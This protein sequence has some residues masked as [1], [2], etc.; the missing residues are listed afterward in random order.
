VEQQFLNA[1]V[2]KLKRLATNT[3]GTAFYVSEGENLISVL[4]E[5]ERFVA[6]QKS[7]Q[8]VVPL[9]DWKYL[10]GLIALFLSLEWFTRKYN[11]LI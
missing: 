7:E 8:K 3:E 1:D 4:L 5:D 2:T 6:V 11:G 10:L 9:V